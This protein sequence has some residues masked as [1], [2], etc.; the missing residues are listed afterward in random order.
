MVSQMVERIAC[1]L[2]DRCLIRG[3]GEGL[4]RARRTCLCNVA[5]RA[6]RHAPAMRPGF[7]PDAQRREARVPRATPQSGNVRARKAREGRYEGEKAI[8]MKSRARGRP[9]RSS[10]GASPAT[11]L[12][13]CRDC[14]GGLPWE[15]K[16]YGFHGLVRRCL[17]PGQTQAQGLGTFT[18]S[19][20]LD[21]TLHLLVSDS[22]R[23][24]S[25]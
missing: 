16:F 14:A 13:C 12:A 15:A 1:H 23:S 17:T 6:D 19:R 18:L 3:R 5:E 2:R 20:Q 4:H 25:A 21:A 11:D 9:F 10:E 7:R 8:E 24:A 22:S